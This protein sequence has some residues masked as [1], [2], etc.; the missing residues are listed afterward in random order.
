MRVT[1][2]PHTPQLLYNGRPFPADAPILRAS[3]RGFRYGDGIFETVRIHNGRLFQWPLHRARLF[4]G[5]GALSLQLDITEIESGITDL[6]A[7]N[8]VSTGLIRI[9][10]ARSGGERGYKPLS[11]SSE[12]IIETGD[13][14]PFEWRPPVS[15]RISSYKRPT[16]E[17]LPAGIKVA[18]GLTSS[19]AGIEAIDTGFSDAILLTD[20][21]SVSEATS[22]NLFWRTGDR[23]YT[24]SLECGIIAGVLRQFLCESSLITVI[25]GRFELGH[26]LGADEV[27]L[28]NV[29]SGIQPIHEIAHSE[30]RHQFDSFSTARRCFDL[31]NHHLTT[32]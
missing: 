26:L 30:L 10:V 12:V 15:V 7:L 16:S 27:F 3:S 31:L 9:A 24:P 22:S 32:E 18:Q 13:A 25:E 23:I 20:D 11:R 14:P 1:P 19:L 17:M 5:A 8:S 28:T 4:R 2:S 21:N 29:I 6:L